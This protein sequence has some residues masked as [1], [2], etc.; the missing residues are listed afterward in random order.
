MTVDCHFEEGRALGFGFLGFGRMF[1]VQLNKSTQ[2]Y[3]ANCSV[4]GN[5]E[6][7]KQY[8]DLLYQQGYSG[9]RVPLGTFN[10]DHE[11]IHPDFR[12]IECCGGRDGM[13]PDA[14]ADS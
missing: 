1:A 4:E 11:D 14:S 6:R 10:K 12:S 7:E 13:Y 5:I 3:T 2:T 8:L 9:D